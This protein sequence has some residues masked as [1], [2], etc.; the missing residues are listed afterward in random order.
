M[1]PLSWLTKDTHV[2]THCWTEVNWK[3]EV[4]RE[5]FLYKRVA[6]FICGH[7]A[8]DS[9]RGLKNK[10]NNTTDSVNICCNCNLNMI[11]IFCSYLPIAS[12]MIQLPKPRH[13]QSRGK[14]EW[15]LWK[16]PEFQGWALSRLLKSGLVRY[17][18][19]KE[20]SGAAPILQEVDRSC[21]DRARLIGKLSINPVP[22]LLCPSCVSR[23]KRSPQ[24]HFCVVAL[25]D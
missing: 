5:L 2:S 3:I 21:Q 11:I 14:R 10:N 8:T 19:L 15:L 22:Q 6:I 20:R 25:Q 23:G 12:S 17:L 24:E 4:R 18:S 7:V 1:N 9:K 13:F 16:H